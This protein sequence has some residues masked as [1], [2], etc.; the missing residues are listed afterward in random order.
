ML[1]LALLFVLSLGGCSRNQKDSDD[2]AKSADP[3]VVD[4]TVVRVQ[5]ANI[6]AELSVSGNLVALPNTD[7]KLAALVPGRI[8]H[9]FVSEGDHV[10]AGQPLAD[11]ENSSLKDQEKQA[12][13]ATA[14]ARA[15]LENARI[16][17][18]RNEG[19]LQRGIASR[20][21]VE[22]ART[23]LAV[24]EAAL[25]QAAAG[26]SAARTL[27]SRAVIRAPFAGTVVHRFLS[28]GEQV[29][30]SSG[31]PVVELA[32][33]DT[34]ELLGT[35]PAAHLAQIRVGED[36]PFET[37]ATPGIKFT[38]RVVSILPAVDP[39]TNN[40][41]I[42][43]RIANPKHLLKLGMFITLNVPL[44]QGGPRLV[45][46]R[47]AIYPDETGAPHVYRLQSEQVEAVSV[48]LG[49]QTKDVAELLSGVREG[50]TVV[51]TGGYGLR[52]K[53][54]VRVKQ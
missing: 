3:A 2:A 17:A 4:V 48:E 5:R 11:L 22:D 39:A 49:V 28:V 8:A 52:D 29:D 54:K 19:L 34:L 12:E 9:V 44:K 47:Q 51:L 27:S 14:Q 20:K 15:N 45:V 18:Q 7:A 33:I 43:I 40:G 23:Q 24:N 30:G 21:E 13:A 35:V 42:R 36:F 32:N 41:G 26:L 46:P 37:S 6:E 38:G 1:P 25:K 16:S 53:A 50:D 10:S 31:Q